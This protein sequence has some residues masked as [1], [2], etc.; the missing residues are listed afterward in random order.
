MIDGEQFILVATELANA[1]TEAH[2]RTSVSRA[3]YA[4][5]H[6]ARSA[7]EGI[8]H[9]P[10]GPQGHKFVSDWLMGHREQ[11]LSE[12]GSSLSRLYSN[13]L[14]A[15]YDVQTRTLRQNDALLDLH[16]AQAIIV[17]IRKHL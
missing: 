16:R 6:V 9:V 10:R 3:Y 13:R 1:N 14:K 7:I 12:A 8:E 17:A 5:Y 2:W 11:E 15:D 4:V